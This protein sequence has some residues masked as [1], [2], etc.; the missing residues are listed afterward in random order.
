[1]RCPVKVLPFGMHP[2]LRA[3]ASVRI[4][5]PIPVS[6]TNRAWTSPTRTGSVTRWERYVNGVPVIAGERIGG[7]IRPGVRPPTSPRGTPVS[8]L[9]R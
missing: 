2:T 6:S 8:L 9:S 7:G 1:M 4:V 3:T 5:G